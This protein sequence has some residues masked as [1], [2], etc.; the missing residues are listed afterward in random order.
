MNLGNKQVV[1]CLLEKIEID[2]D[3]CW[4]FIGAVTNKGYGKMKIRQSNQL[5]HRVSY[6]VHRGAIPD[7]MCVLH[8]CDAPP[9]CNPEHLFLGS[10]G[11]NEQDGHQQR[12]HNDREHQAFPVVV[13]P[14]QHCERDR[15]GGYSVGGPGP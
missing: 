1:D 7:G 14:W 2:G 9:C 3:G 8:R 4:I 5:A 11:D 15:C 10:H 6:R 13:K 12:A